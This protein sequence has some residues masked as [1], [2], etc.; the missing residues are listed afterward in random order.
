MLIWCQTQTRVIRFNK[1]RFP[2]KCFNSSYKS[3]RNELETP[4]TTLLDRNIEFIL[5]KCNCMNLWREFEKQFENACACVC[6]IWQ[7]TI[8]E[9]KN[10]K[11][12]DRREK[13]FEQN[14]RQTQQ[15]AKSN[16]VQC[17]NCWAAAQFSNIPSNTR[18]AST[19]TITVTNIK[20]KKIELHLLDCG[21]LHRFHEFL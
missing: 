11:K 18:I 8:R 6:A 2:M 17:M 20:S 13:K 9:R 10:T 15:I 3:V 21:W 14:W 5:I 16:T 19:I 7:Q 12:K 1:T 4:L